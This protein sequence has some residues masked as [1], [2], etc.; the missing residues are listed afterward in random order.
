MRILTILL[1]DLSQILRDRKSFLFLLAMPLVFTL[2]MG[3]AYQGAAAKPDPRLPLGWV[4]HD[5]SG[6]LSLALHASLAS[7]DSLRLVELDESQEA[8]AS[9]QVSAGKLAGAVVIPAGFSRGAMSASAPQI[10]LLV[11]PASITGQ[12]I[13]ELVRVPVTRLMSAAEIARL[14]TASLPA[15]QPVEA[16]KAFQQASQLWAQQAQNGPQIVVIAAQGKSTGQVSFQG[17]PYNQSSPGMLVMF[18]V[19]GLV[20]SATI[21][22]QERKL[23]TL[24]RMLTTS[25]NRSSLI[26]GHLLAMFVLALMQQAVLVTFGQI[27]LKVDYSRQPLGIL[28]VMVAVALWAATLGLLIGVLAKEEQ[29]ATLYALIAMFLFSALGGA[30]FPLESSGPAFAA[31]GRLTPTAWAMTGFQNILIRGLDSASTLLPAIILLAYA[32]L[33]FGLAVWRFNKSS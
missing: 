31:V 17:N 23:R 22:V 26:A 32:V 25:L 12:S 13:L 33:F 4:N 16:E 3:F 11:N 24:E 30:W 5:P 2:F 29:R 14:H 27:F 9:Q 7:S 21:V 10:V 19:F 6:K 20:T 18:A 8:E 28:L 1:K 15:G